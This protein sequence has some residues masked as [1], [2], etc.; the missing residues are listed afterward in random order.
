MKTNLLLL[1]TVV[2]SACRSHESETQITPPPQVHGE[3]VVFPQDSPQMAGLVVEPVEVCKGSS[4]R[5]NGRL[6]WDDDVTVRVFTPFGGRV[7]K[8]LAEVGQTVRPGE[9]LVMIASPEYSQTQAE[10]RKASTDLLLAER[11]LARIQE[12][13]QHGAAPQKDVQSAEAD[14]ARAQSEKER[15]A[16]RLAFLGGNADKIGDVYQLPSPLG[17]VIVEKSINPGQEVRADQMLAN[18]APLFSP[19]FVVTDPARLWIQLDATEQDAPRLKRGQP[20]VIRSRAHPDHLFEGKIEV[21]ADYLD[22]STRTIKVRGTVDNSKRLLRGEMFVTVDL[23]ATEQNGLDVSPRAVFLKGE[24]HY[25]FLEEGRGQYSRREIKI[26]REHEGRI[27]VIDGIQAGQ[28]V[29][30]NGCLLLDQLLQANSG[31]S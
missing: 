20:L 24:K 27:L 8:I 18:A 29:V 15:A 4:I 7:S 14:F 22:P 9:P 30:T 19:L 13:F 21:I 25:V 2:L 31:G 6:V 5:L 17:G 3:K 11:S 1:L 23:P 26:G 10:A 16:S 28:R 12:L